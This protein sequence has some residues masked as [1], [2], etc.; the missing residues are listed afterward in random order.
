M[1]EF[2]EE[3]EP[4]FDYRRVQPI[5]VVCLEDEEEEEGVIYARKKRKT[6]EPVVNGSNQEKVV[7]VVDIDDKEDDWLLPPPKVSMDAS[8][9]IGEDSTLKELR[10]K[11]QEL[12]SFAQSAK[13]MLQEVK[14]SA[15][16]ELD[17]SLQTSVDAASE[18]T[19]KPPE[20]AKIVISIQDKDGVKQFRV[21]MDDKFERIFK[22]YA[23]KVKL[24][25]RHLVFSFD[26]DRINPS[27][28][29]SG[30]GMEDDDII[31][32]HVKSS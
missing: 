1:A 8:R 24:D 27:Q 16:R 21:Y 31:E 13:E 4:L 32:V 14:E 15:K 17:N 5:N 25:Q 22:M 18:E 28:T 6:S 3:L 23:D 26:G 12:V 20:R 10:L 29:P 7:A 9:S 11:K 19:L 2:K 30:L